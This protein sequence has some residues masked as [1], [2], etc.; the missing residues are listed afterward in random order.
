MKKLGIILLITTSCYISEEL[1]PDQNIWEYDL[2]Q[3]QQLD[4]ELLLDIDSRIRFQDGDFG[5]V[6][7]LAIVRNNTLVFE[8]YYSNELGRFSQQ[9]IGRAGLSITLA[10]LGVAID[11]RLIS[12]EDSIYRYLPEYTSIFQADPSKRAIKVKDVLMHRTGISWNETIERNPSLNDLFLMKSQD[13]WL[14]YYLSRP[15]A[16]V[17]IYTLSTA[18]GV[19]MAKII[20]NATSRDF[21]EFLTDQLFEPLEINHNSI[22]TD[23]VGNYNGGDGYRISLLD[24]SKIGFLFLNE[25][26]WQGRTVL[27]NNFVDEALSRQHQFSQSSFTNSIGYFWNFFGENIQG[28]LGTDYSTISFLLGEFGQSIFIVPEEN[29]IVTIHSNN[30]IGFNFQSFNLFLEIT[31]SINQ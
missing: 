13:D 18:N 30:S 6:Q 31:R 27:S 5:A 21:N 2:P 23:D 15:L 19:L 3:N 16:G 17:G 24:F 9:N 28:N 29:M 8:N 4:Q 26:F 14:Q 20:Q 12:V 1:P 11:Q 10:A 22:E 25:G 7:A